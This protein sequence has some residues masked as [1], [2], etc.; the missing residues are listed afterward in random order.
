MSIVGDVTEGSAG[1]QAIT[2]GEHPQ[3]PYLFAFWCDVKPAASS[4]VKFYCGYPDGFVI[5]LTFDDPWPDYCK[6]T[7]TLNGQPIDN[8]VFIFDLRDAD[9]WIEF[10]CIFAGHISIYLNTWQTISYYTPDSALTVNDNKYGF[11]VTTGTAQFRDFLV[12]RSYY[13]GDGR[14]DCDSDNM[15]DGTCVAGDLFDCE[16]P[17]PNWDTVDSDA[18]S[19]TKISKTSDYD[20]NQEVFWSAGH[21]RLEDDSW[22]TVELGWSTPYDIAP[23]HTSVVRITM[24][25]ND[26]PG[27][28]SQVRT[29]LEVVND[30]VVQDTYYTDW[31]EPDDLSGDF[32]VGHE[33]NFYYDEQNSKW[34]FYCNT[35][36]LCSHDF[37]YHFLRIPVK[38]VSL[39]WDHLRHLY[40]SVDNASATMWNQHY[41]CYGPQYCASVFTVDVSGVTSKDKVCGLYDMEPPN[42][43]YRCERGHETRELCGYEWHDW[44]GWNTVCQVTLR[45]D[46]EYNQG[47]DTT[48]TTLRI[49]SVGRYECGD[50]AWIR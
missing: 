42:D 37:H 39:P 3:K 38:E 15:L 50:T 45:V 24:E 8:G 19:Y 22:G 27:F 35:S 23:A 21:N 6:V 40:M 18:T 49:E 11:G 25:E 44:S 12:K 1:S 9:E 2:K 7:I 16:L 41:R 36:F 31:S 32:G 17:A 47:N 34:T 48:R 29:K 26:L 30:G 46:C 20:W 14:E 10:K 33:L 13:C 28:F 43:S 5:T 4:E